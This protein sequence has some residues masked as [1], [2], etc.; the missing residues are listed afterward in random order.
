M[1]MYDKNV[2]LYISIRTQ[3]LKVKSVINS[4]SDN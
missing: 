1:K 2:S 4:N 3:A